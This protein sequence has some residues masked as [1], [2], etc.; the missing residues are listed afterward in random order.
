MEKVSLVNLDDKKNM[1]LTP[2]ACS[3]RF[4]QVG[5][6]WLQVVN[7]CCRCFC[8]VW[9]LATPWTVVCLDPLPME[10]SN[11][12]YWSGVLFPTPGDLPYPGIEPRSLVSPALAGRFLTANATKGYIHFLNLLHIP[13]L[14]SLFLTLYGHLLSFTSTL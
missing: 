9:R 8:C 11:Q 3:L 12:R 1:W 7:N 6:K 2:N 5:F 4:S 13:L 14:W 10:F